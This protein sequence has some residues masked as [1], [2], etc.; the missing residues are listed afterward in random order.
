MSKSPNFVGYCNVGIVKVNLITIF[1]QGET[2]GS[3]DI[4]Y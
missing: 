4:E 1:T 2:R 3:L